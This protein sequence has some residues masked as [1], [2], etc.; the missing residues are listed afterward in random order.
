MRYLPGWKHEHLKASVKNS[1]DY[2]AILT[3][4]DFWNRYS[5][6]NRVLIFQHDSGLLREGIDEFLEW[7][8]VGAP[9]YDGAPWAHP[10]NKGGNGG[11]SL[12]NPRMMIA[13]LNKFRYP[14]MQGN[15][16]VFYVHHLEEVGGKLAPYEVC[17]KFSC[18]TVFCLGTMGY[19][20]IDKHM[21]QEQTEEILN[22]YANIMS[23]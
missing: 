14:P 8:Y 5:E 6:Y 17:K 11:L 22:Q 16:D 21:S 12:R 19:H 15:E 10:Q 23:E 9:W 7:D 20:A 4:K 13:I 18:E 3:R 2:N 1:Y